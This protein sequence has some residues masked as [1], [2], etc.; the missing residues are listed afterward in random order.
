[1]RIGLDF[2]NTLVCYD[3]LFYL[4]A[5]EENLL[6]EDIPPNKTD[7]RNA[8][9]RSGREPDWTRLQGLAYG[10]RILEAEPF[11]GLQACLQSW[12]D[13]GWELIVVSHK[14]RT[15]YAGEAHDLHAAARAWIDRHLHARGL[16]Q[17]AP[18][19]F[20]LT[21]QA[22]LERIA[23]LNLD[24]FVDDLPDILLDCQNVAQKW[25]FDPHQQHPERPEFKR[26]Q[27]W[28]QLERVS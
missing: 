9:R 10:P 22:K 5:R 27:A 16:L 4:L 6:P 3:R 28:N 13:Q 12:Q 24:A 17:Q 20:E 8:L 25:L 18:A 14:T 15:P 19:Y 1:M 23:Q 21:R 2:D 7:I 26:W 11:P